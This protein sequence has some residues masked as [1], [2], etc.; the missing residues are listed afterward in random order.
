[1][2]AKKTTPVQTA[3]PAANTAPATPHESF[4]K[5]AGDLVSKSLPEIEE[6]AGVA[7]QAAG[8]GLIHLSPQASAIATALQLI[9]AARAARQQ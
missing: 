4:L 8:A 1:M 9:A 7:A 2:K 6:I 5:H 3:T